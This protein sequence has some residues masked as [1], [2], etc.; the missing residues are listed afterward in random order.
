MGARAAKRELS[1]PART[2]P[3]KFEARC[4]ADSKAPRRRSSRADS[5]RPTRTSSFSTTV[6][7]LL[8]SSFTC[9]SKAPQRKSISF[10]VSEMTP[11]SRSASSTRS[12]ASSSPTQAAR[13][14]WVSA[15]RAMEA[16]A[17]EALPPLKT[18]LALSPASVEGAVS[19]GFLRPRDATASSCA[20]RRLSCRAA[21]AHASSALQAKSA[22][23]LQRS[24]RSRERSWLRRLKLSSVWVRDDLMA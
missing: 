6:S 21:A 15:P 4:A 18:S 9:S 19:S 23:D 7:F 8:R 17:S 24:S 14:T 20:D 5:M 10:R 22:R 16:A 13:A 12:S 2:L 1:S 11:F 3:P